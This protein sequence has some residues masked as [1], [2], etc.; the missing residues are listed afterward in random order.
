MT[1]AGAVY[2]DPYRPDF[3]MNPYPV[4][5][6]LREEAPLYYNEQYDFYALSRFSDVESG[7]SNREALSSSRGD[8]LEYIKADMQIP[9][10][11]FIWEDPPAHTV[12]RGVLTR[13]FTP[14]RMN[15]LEEKIRAYCARC[16]DPLVGAGRFDFITDFG[17]DMPMRVIGMLLGIPEQDQ[18]AIRDKLDTSLRTEAGKPLDVANASYMGAGF[19]EYI[20]WRSQHPSDDLMTELLQVEF[21]DETGAKRKLTRQE[22]LTFVNIL[23][24][25]GNETTTRLIGWTGKVLSD[26][27]E[28]RAELVKNPALIPNAIEELL[29]YEPPGPSVARYV[30]RDVELHGQT[31]PA[32]SAVLLLVAS[33]NRDERRYPDGD[34]FDIHRRGPPHITFGRGIHACLGSALARVE[35]RVAVDELLKRF[36]TWTVDLDNAKLSSTSTVRGWDNMPAFTGSAGRKVAQH[37]ATADATKQSDT[38]AAPGTETWELTL[39]TPMGPQVMTAQ[40][41]RSG[42]A[43]TGTISSGDM[44]SKDI[45]GKSSGNTLTWTLSLTKPVSIKLSF[46]ADVDGD[47]MTGTVKLGMFG[48]AAL[49]GRRI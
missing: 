41:L 18:E 11:M 19:E 37:E 48:K 6:R 31:V 40:I 36:P 32:G 15:D 16:L 47:Q 34:L 17:A 21:Q 29:R 35:G 27:P 49:A 28:Q 24:G 4:F 8:V 25:A 9:S 44:G 26:H 43:F 42:A 3:W 12:H 13:V 46:E 14:R 5:R 30:Q 20:D 39:S 22:I 7:F 10:G 2:W 45:T 23:A 1:S 33:A 38:N